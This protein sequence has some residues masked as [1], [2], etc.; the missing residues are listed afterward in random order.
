MEAKSSESKFFTYVLIS[1]DSSLPIREKKGETSGGL[2][3]DFLM[4][5]AKAYFVEPQNQLLNQ[6]NNANTTEKKSLIDEIR[7]QLSN[8]NNNLSGMNDDT[9]VEM[10]KSAYKATSCEILALTVPTK[11]NNY[12]AV[13]MYIA[14]N[15]DSSSPHLGAN[16]RAMDLKKACNYTREQEIFGD[17]FVGRYKDNE[18]ENIWMRKDFTADEVSFDA[19]WCQLARTTRSVSSSTSSTLSNLLKTQQKDEVVEQD[20]NNYKWTQTQNEIEI[21]ILLESHVKTKDLEVVF[22]KCFCQ[23]NLQD[24]ILISGPTGGDVL[25]GDSTYFVQDVLIEKEKKREL[26]IILSKKDVTSWW[27]FAIKIK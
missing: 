1:S 22:Q 11:Q 10:V 24:K 12:E 7:R 15:S 20:E 27:D 25:V 13:S 8:S 18:E 14:P 5:E 17:V 19:D 21:K 2:N 3:D 9:L 16:K 23:V 4:K 26:C 6:I